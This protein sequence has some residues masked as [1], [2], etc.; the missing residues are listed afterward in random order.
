MRAATRNAFLGIL[1]AGLLAAPAGS[2]LAQS[3]WGCGDD[4]GPRAGGPADRREHPGRRREIVQTFPGRPARLVVGRR[5]YFYREGRFYRP[6]GAGF[7]LVGAPIGAVIDFLPPGCITLAIGDRPIFYGAG[8]Y[9]RRLGPRYVVVDS[10]LGAT[11]DAVPEGSDTLAVGGQTLYY[12][13][14][15]YYQL[16][17]AHGYDI[18][19]P[20]EGVQVTYL[21][22][23]T[24]SLAAGD[25]TVYCSHGVFYN[26][27]AG[28]D[29][30]TVI[31]PPEGAAVPSLP[32]DHRV[33][34]IRARRYYVYNGTYFRPVFRGGR[35]F[36]IVTTPL[37]RRHWR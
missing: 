27:D 22:E 37:T 1:L 21:P 3:A 15:S 25:G 34:V 36:Y 9:Y 29:V 20:P 13:E 23:D 19:Y 24:D 33:V 2:A 30:Y 28:Q 14:G 26:Y 8:I 10:P 4:R 18:V 5:A 11:V 32:F 16:N 35:T 6:A 31:T 12:Y 7:A 17:P